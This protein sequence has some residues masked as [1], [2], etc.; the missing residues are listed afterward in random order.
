LSMIFSRLRLKSCLAYYYRKLVIPR[1]VHRAR[2]VLT[3]SEDSRQRIKALRLASWKVAVTRAGVTAPGPRLDLAKVRS[4]YGLPE[5]YFL[6]P[7]AE[8]KRKNLLGLLEAYQLLPEKERPALAIFGLQREQAKEQWPGRIPDGAS[9]LGYLPDDDLYA[10]MSGGLGLL[11]PS[12]GEGFGLPALEAMAFGLPVV[13][14]NGGAL[15]ELCGDAA[16]L[17]DPGSSGEIA[18]AAAR[19]LGE[20]G[21]A[22]KL[23]AAGKRRAHCFSWRTTA[24]ETLAVYRQVLE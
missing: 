15:S 11:F 8:D 9:F 7:S 19:L 6:A 4:K 1:G 13:A 23:I 20:K 21:L 3:V 12:L 16:L 10:L 5:K 18:A 24:A 22:R 2:A 14:G 17:V